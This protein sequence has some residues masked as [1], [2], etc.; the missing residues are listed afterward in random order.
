LGRENVFADH[1]LPV[2][3]HAVD[4]GGLFLHVL[5]LQLLLFQADHF[6]EADEQEVV[7]HLH[8]HGDDHVGQRSRDEDLH[9]VLKHQLRAGL[10]A[11]EA[12]E[13]ADQDA[14]YHVDDRG[15]GG[16]PLLEGLRSGLQ[17]DPLVAVALTQVFPGQRATRYLVV[18][19]P[20]LAVFV[21]VLGVVHNVFADTHV[22]VVPLLLV[23]RQHRVTVE[24]AQAER[25]LDDVGIG[26]GAPELV[27]V[28]VHPLQIG[29][30]LGRPGG[31]PVGQRV[32]AGH[33][34]LLYLLGQ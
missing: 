31:G 3:V 28:F 27:V 1:Q 15:H 9:H 5:P 4:D 23:I 8:D 34:Q 25:F 7:V 33:G 19:R 20:R 26:V 2:F 10:V 13:H 24:L 12:R 32:D 14:D 30:H 29:G 16:Q 11:H 6:E 17:R 18:A 21:D 22:H